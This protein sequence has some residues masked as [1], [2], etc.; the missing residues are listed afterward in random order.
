[1][2]YLNIIRIIHLECG[3]PNPLVGNWSLRT[4]TQ[5]IKRGKGNTTVQKSPLLPKHLHQILIQ[6]DLKVLK[7]LQFWTATL[8]AF[9]GLLRIGN[10]TV[11]KQP[12]CVTRESVSVTSKGIVIS[13]NQSKTIQFKE[14]EHQI[15]LPYIKDHP[16]CP[17][18]TLL[19]FM[20]RTPSCLDSSP[21]LSVPGKTGKPPVAL[22]SS[23]YRR[24]L[25]FLASRCTDL[26]NC[27]THSLRRGGATWLMSCGVPVASIKI[28]GDWRSDSVFKYLLPDTRA[29]FNL[30]S[31]ACTS[32]P[33]K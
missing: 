5:G 16:L 2:Q 1:M 25:S 4:V 10:I 32:L 14:R 12:N 31:S 11:S 26:P 28:L 24:R 18:T 13:V 19:N 23:V 9:F 22:S 6:L 17:T 7:D 20:S 27:S 21:L 30:I 15:I 33:F 29:K 3:I 8:C